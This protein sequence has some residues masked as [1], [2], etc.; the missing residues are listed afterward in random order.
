MPTAGRHGASPGLSLRASS[1]FTYSAVARVSSSAS[2]RP[3]KG[4]TL[5]CNA[6][7]GRPLLLGQGFRSAG[8]PW[9]Y[10]SSSPVLTM[11]SAQ[12]PSHPRTTNWERLLPRSRAATKPQATTISPVV[13]SC[14]AH[15]AIGALG[16][17]AGHRCGD[18]ATETQITEST[19]PGPAEWPFEA[20]QF[21]R[22]RALEDLFAGVQPLAEG[23][24]FVI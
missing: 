12:P 5:V 2:T 21:W 6:D 4:R 13:P 14:Q 23:E 11:H 9:N 24:S 17:R 16:P 3:P 8:I 10:S 19:E 22:G 18:R 15:E 20:D 1:I 7:P